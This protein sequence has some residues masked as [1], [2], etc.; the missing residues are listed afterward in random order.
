MEKELLNELIVIFAFSVVIFFIFIKAKIPAIV[1][2]LLTGVFIG[3]YGLGMVKAVHEVELLSEIG[4]ILLLFTIGMEFSFGNLIKIKRAIFL[5]GT[6]QVGM[7]ILVTY[8]VSRI[9]GLPINQS[10]FWGFLISLSSTAIVLRIIQERAEIDSPHARTT[11][12]ILIF[13]D[14]IVVPMML[15]T[16]L[17]A[18]F[19]QTG[20]Q[21]ILILI[22]KSLFIILLTFVG[23][24]WLVPAILY[25][26]A[27]TKNRELFLLTIMVICFAVAGLTYSMGLSLALGAF[28][29]G[30]IISESEYNHEALGN[31]LPLRDLFTSL[32]FV[33]IG[34]MLNLNILVENIGLIVALTVGIIILKTVI[35]GIATIAM[36]FPLRT[37]VLVGTKLGQI[38]EF[39][40]ILAKV[41]LTVGLLTQYGLQVFIGVSILTM[42]LSPYIIKFSPILS[43][44]L[45]KIP[46]P[47][48]IKVGFYKEHHSKKVSYSNH[49]VVIG[50]GLNGRNL[51]R[52]LVA[53]NIP[54]YII[55]NNP[56]IVRHER[57]NG[58][59]IL[60]GDATH[61]AVLNYV[62]I[63]E[64]KVIVI[65]IS[66][67]SATKK[68]IKAIRKLSQEVYIIVR[69]RYVEEMEHLYKLGANDVIPEE[70]ETSIEI[71]TKVLEEY[72]VSKDEIEKHIEE[73]RAG[74]YH[75]LTTMGR[76]K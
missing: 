11:L 57:K 35:G 34:M 30:L 42:A 5:G 15:V 62:G 20:N 43:E 51:T 76:I 13:Q 14:I 75:L 26:V 48:I 6:L 21:G 73:I 10:V 69:T 66:D 45:Q 24:K 50:F 74:R 58:H 52:T 55:E 23:S 33:S 65:A 17:L 53:S 19:A 3:P 32:F 7:T 39:S 67:S 1:G 25:Q 41:G 54:Y 27:K 64:A 61:E 68:I 8:I 70:F 47:E 22:A 44:L 4:V 2:L 16:P 31:V 18:G 29:A 46:I 28:L 36:G 71:F 56:Q 72:E 63:K 9:I 38:G 12:G 49:V 40:F 37:S 59:Q 60:H